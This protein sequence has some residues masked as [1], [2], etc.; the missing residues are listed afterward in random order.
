MACRPYCVRLFLICLTAVSILFIPVTADP[1]GEIAPVNPYFTEYI[2]Q[3]R[4]ISSDEAIEVCT[5]EA[6]SVA[7]TYAFGDIPNPVQIVWAPD[8]VQKE[9]TLYDAA[10]PSESFFSLVD[11]GRVTPVKNQGYCGSCWAFSSTGSLESWV[12]SDTGESPT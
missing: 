8:R 5:P 11:E 9:A 10:T 6:L 4:G 2:A 3:M 1:T 12:L 7:N